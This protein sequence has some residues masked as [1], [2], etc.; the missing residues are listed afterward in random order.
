MQFVMPKK[1]STGRF[2]LVALALAGSAVVMLSSVAPLS[3]GASTAAEP[4]PAIAQPTVELGTAGSF[5]A[6]ASAATGG[7]G[8][9]R[10]DGH[11]D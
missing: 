7:Q 11:V 1:G 5:S 10:H 3:L 9:G 8:G 2:R 6:L 4:P